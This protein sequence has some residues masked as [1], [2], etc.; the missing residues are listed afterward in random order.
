MPIA[1]AG[2]ALRPMSAIKLFVLGV[3]NQ[4]P[5]HVIAGKRDL[6][7]RMLVWPG[8]HYFG[9]HGELPRWNEDHPGAKRVREICIAR[10]FLIRVER[11]RKWSWFVFDRSP[12]SRRVRLNFWAR[13]WRCLRGH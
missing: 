6:S 10:A 9:T 8:I 13:T 3:G 5:R 1:R 7:R 2:R 11:R 12:R 4:I